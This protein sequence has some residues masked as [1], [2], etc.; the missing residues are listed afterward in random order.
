MM[1]SPSRSKRPVTAPAPAFDPRV[2][3][4][5]DWRADHKPSPL[6]ADNSSKSSHT[7]STS[8]LQFPIKHVAPH[9]PEGLTALDLTHDHEYRAQ[10]KLL[11]PHPETSLWQNPKG[12]PPLPSSVA[13]TTWG[14]NAYHRP[15]VPIMIPPRNPPAYLS[16]HNDWE[17]PSPRPVSHI[18]FANFGGRAPRAPIRPPVN[19]PLFSSKDAKPG[20]VMRSASEDHFRGN[21]QRLSP[22]TRHG[23]RPADKPTAPWAST[24]GSTSIASMLRS[25]SH[26]QFQEFGAL[27]T[28]NARQGQAPAARIK[29]P[30]PY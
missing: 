2:Q 29:N 13:K 15:V 30:P 22:A 19:P 18:H 26:L 16:A 8:H 25:S 4:R 24:A 27:A 14:T 1:S 21:F 10:R 20:T 17:A 6:M 9:M 5:P 7:Q 3:L 28:R 23:S 12:G 11:R